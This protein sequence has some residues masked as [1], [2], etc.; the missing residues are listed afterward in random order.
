MAYPIIPWSAAWRPIDHQTFAP[1]LGQV[2]LFASMDRKDEPPMLL[3][4][5]R[6]EDPYGEEAK[7]DWH[8]PTE[9]GGC[10]AVRIKHFTHYS[11]VVLPWEAQ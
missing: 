4:Y 6:Y 2:A 10:G 9:S 1:R 7:A 8:D 5:D 3:L 11:D